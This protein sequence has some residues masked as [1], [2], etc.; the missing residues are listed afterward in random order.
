MISKDKAILRRG[1]WIRQHRRGL[2]LKVGV[3]IIRGGS[4]IFERGGVVLKYRR[5]ER[6]EKKF[7]PFL[8]LKT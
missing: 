8:G 1:Q 5:A 2:S 7:G 6:G 4:R 3:S